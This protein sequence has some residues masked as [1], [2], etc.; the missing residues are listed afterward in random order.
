MGKKR[1]EMVQSHLKKKKK[2]KIGGRKENTGE[3][4]KE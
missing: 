2:K 4:K 1:T 3:Q